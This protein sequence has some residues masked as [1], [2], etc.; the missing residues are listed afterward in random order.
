MAAVIRPFHPSDLPGMYR[1]CL[2]TGEAGGDATE[3]YRNP[4][5]LAHLYCGPYPVADPSLTFVVADEHG[6][7]GYVVATADS[8]AFGDWLDEHWWPTLRTQY[9]LVDDPHDGT[10]DHVLIRRMHECPGDDRR[11]YATHPAHLHID[12]APR[13]QRQGLGRRLIA[14]LCEALRARGVGGLHLGVDE[15]NQDGIA[16]YERLG[17][18]TLETHEWG[19]TLVLDL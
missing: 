17:F 12:L 19:R 6:I 3:L 10:Q 14:T 7:G 11:V 15:R 8:R 13:L 5:L 4:D 1:L 16:F 18:R 9:P 2:L